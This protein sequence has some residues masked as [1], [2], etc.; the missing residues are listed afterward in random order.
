[1]PQGEIIVTLQGKEGRKPYNY[2]SA[3]E[4]PWGEIPIAILVN[5]NTASAAEVLTAAL[6]E[7][8]GAEVIG[9]TTYGKGVAQTFR[10][11]P[12]L[13]VIKLTNAQWLTPKGNTIH[14][15]GIEPTIPVEPVQVDY[16]GGWGEPWQLGDYGL[17][18]EDIQH[19]LLELGYAEPA[20]MF[21]G[22]YDE[23]TSALVRAFQTAEGLEATG[24]VNDTTAMRIYDRMQELYGDETLDVALKT[25][26]NKS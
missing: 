14:E 4:E 19:Q 1:V 15:V 7:H 12:D 3:Q 8:N 17:Q 6:M 25:L 16:V 22:A 24:Q 13:S 23:A 18:V 2:I 10:Q 5:G 11:L 9:E 20:G 21:Y 26:Q